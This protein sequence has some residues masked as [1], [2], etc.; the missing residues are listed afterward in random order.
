MVAV[1]PWSGWWVCDNKPSRWF[2]VMVVVGAILRVRMFY[3]MCGVILP[4]KV[5]ILW[6]CSSWRNV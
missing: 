6:V 1:E 2:F 5:R 4:G 3:E